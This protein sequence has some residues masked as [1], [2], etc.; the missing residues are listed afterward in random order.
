[1]IGCC[2]CLQAQRSALSVVANCCQSVTSPSLLHSI[3]A[4]LLDLGSRLAAVS[5]CT[6]SGQGAGGD[7]KCTHSIVLAFS[8][9]VDNFILDHN[10]LD[11]ILSPSLLLTL[12][13]LA[14]SH[15]PPPPPPPP[16][17]IIHYLSF[18]EPG[19]HK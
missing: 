12:Q 14:S 2:C 4:S 18:K 17:P 19:H 13:Q 1:M 8:R 6:T 5:G 3:T 15:L 10:T 11:L 7:S 9:L 16:L